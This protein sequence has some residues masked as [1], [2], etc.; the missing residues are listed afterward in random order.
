MRGGEET[1]HMCIL[2]RCV[3]ASCTT[4]K[5]SKNPARHSAAELPAHGH[6]HVPTPPQVYGTSSAAGQGTEVTGLSRAG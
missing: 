3:N 2:R 5:L 4:A 6:L 1:E